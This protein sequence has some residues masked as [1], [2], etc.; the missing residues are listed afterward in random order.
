MLIFFILSKKNGRYK[1]ISRA[2]DWFYWIDSSFLKLTFSVLDQTFSYL[3]L[4]SNASALTSSLSILAPST[5]CETHLSEV[6][7]RHSSA[8]FAI[9][10]A[11]NNSWRFSKF[12]KISYLNLPFLP[13]SRCKNS[14]PLGEKFWGWNWFDG[15]WFI[16]TKFCF[17]SA[18]PT[19]LVSEIFFMAFGRSSPNS[20]LGWFPWTSVNC[21]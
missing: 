21:R 20:N 9:E 1:T 18:W 19:L 15:M 12:L 11:W 10:P 14:Y 4:E 2:W 17:L 5:V 16:S 3:F 6:S 8:L 7:W 13:R